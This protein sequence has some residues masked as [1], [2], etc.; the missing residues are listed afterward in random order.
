MLVPLGA[1]VIVNPNDFLGRL[2]SATLFDG[3]VGLDWKN[4]NLELYATNLFD[5]RN[6]LTRGVSCGSC[7]RTL[8]VPG[9]PRTIGLRAGYKF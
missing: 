3:F 8:V 7:S 9:R 5:K 2:R 1:G 6:D 4:Y